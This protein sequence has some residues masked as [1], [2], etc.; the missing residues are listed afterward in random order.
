MSLC[1]KPHAVLIVMLLL[2]QGVRAAEEGASPSPVGGQVQTPDLTPVTFLDAPAQA[3]VTL[4]REGKPSAVICLADPQPTTNLA[5][6]VSELVEDIRLTT[7]ARLELVR[8]PPAAGSAAIVIGDC[9]ESRRAGIDAARIPIEGFV[10]KTAPNRVF[11]VG[12]TQ[13]LPITDTKRPGRGCSNDGTA[14]AVADFLERT[15]GVRWYWPVAAGGRS[16]ISQTTLSVAPTHYSDQPVFRKREFS[17]TGGYKRSSWKAN[18]KPGAALLPDALLDPGTQQ[19]ETQ[20]MLA[21]LRAGSSWPYVIQVHEPQKFSAKVRAEHP[22]MFQ[23][24]T[25]GKRSPVMFCYSSP[26][27]FA[28]LIQ[29]CEDAWDHGKSVSW[30]TKTCVTVSPGDEPVLCQCPACTALRDPARG[31]YGTGCRARF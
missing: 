5:I 28:Y 12:S 27:T 3:P 10:V 25:D 9:E 14:W 21:G 30:V 23:L 20:P 15:V 2:A 31:T 19:I 29:G 18:R 4:V 26:H 13:P 17:N 24:R 6:L 7:G 16:V 22:D 11:L 8:T 1:A